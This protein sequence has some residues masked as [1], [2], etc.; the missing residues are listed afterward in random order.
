MNSMASSWLIHRVAESQPQPGTSLTQDVGCGVNMAQH[1]VQYCHDKMIVDTR[2]HIEVTVNL[3]H[4]EVAS[5]QRR[6]LQF[7][8]ATCYC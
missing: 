7:L 8:S 5:N 6:S 1:G 4:L 2:T 3:A